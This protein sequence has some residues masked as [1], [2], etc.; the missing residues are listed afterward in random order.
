M[1]SDNRVLSPVQFAQ[2]LKLLHDESC[3]ENLRNAFMKLYKSNELF[4]EFSEDI[5][6]VFVGKLKIAYMDELGLMNPRDY[7][8]YNNITNIDDALRLFSRFRNNL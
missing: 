5:K 4:I 1:P 3:D 6:I 7:L 2:F 8:S